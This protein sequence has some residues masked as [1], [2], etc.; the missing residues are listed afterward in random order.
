MRDGH[1]DD[2]LIPVPCPQ[3]GSE[4]PPGKAEGGPRATAAC[5]SHVQG[6]P[7]PLSRLLPV[8]SFLVQ[9]DKEKGNELIA[10]V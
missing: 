4:V 1:P 2:T 9:R 5:L 10:V 3:P 6:H 7:R 8:T